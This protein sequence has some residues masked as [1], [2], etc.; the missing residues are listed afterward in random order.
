MV[1]FAGMLFLPDSFGIL[2]WI[3][4]TFSGMSLAETVL[5]VSYTGLDENI[6]EVLIGFIF[7]IFWTGSLLSVACIIFKLSR[8]S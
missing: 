7:S 2:R 6:A 1:N 3:G 8:I 4:H 5:E